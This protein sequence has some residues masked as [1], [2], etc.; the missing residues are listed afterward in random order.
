M[1]NHEILLCGTPA[2]NTMIQKTF[3]CSV[4]VCAF[5]FFSFLDLKDSIFEMLKCKNGCQI[6]QYNYCI[7][8]QPTPKNMCSPL[9]G[10]PTPRNWEEANPPLK[11]MGQN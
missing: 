9:S 4:C 6:I 3:S 2:L 8:S 10:L 7:L 11:N 5:V 1:K